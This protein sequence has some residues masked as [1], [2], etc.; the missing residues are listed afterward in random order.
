MMDA[1]EKEMQGESDTVIREVT[2]QVSFW[3]VSCLVRTYS[4]R[5]NKHRWRTYSMMVQK[6]SPNA[7]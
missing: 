4:S 7:Q 2:V 5:W 3:Y 1:V 6:H